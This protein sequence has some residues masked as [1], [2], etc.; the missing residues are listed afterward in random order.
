MYIYFYQCATVVCGSPWLC[1]LLPWWRAHS[2]LQSQTQ[3]SAPTPLHSGSAA[4][5]TP[6]LPLVPTL[7][8]CQMFWSET[9]QVSFFVKQTKLLILGIITLSRDCDFIMFAKGITR[10]WH[11]QKKKNTHTHT[12]NHTNSSSLSSLSV[13]STKTMAAITVGWVVVCVDGWWEQYSPGWVEDS[14][15]MDSSHQWV[16]PVFLLVCRWLLFP[17]FDLRVVWPLCKVFVSRS[18]YLVLS[19]PGRRSVC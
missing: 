19:F 10:S 3:R 13:E 5:S 6:S 18:I 7:T 9:L 16:W 17:V 12:H 15:G 8:N 14:V 11:A 2:S 1:Y 4:L